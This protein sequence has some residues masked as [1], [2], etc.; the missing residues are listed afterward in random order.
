MPK[1]PSIHDQSSVA[2][3][4]LITGEIRVAHYHPP[5]TGL[6]AEWTDFTGDTKVDAPADITEWSVAGD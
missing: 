6:P 3:T 2:Y 1:K 5:E 4:N